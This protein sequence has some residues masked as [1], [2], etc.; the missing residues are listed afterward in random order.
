MLWP[1]LLETRLRIDHYSEKLSSIA[2]LSGEGWAELVAQVFQKLADWSFPWNQGHKCQKTC[3]YCSQWWSCLRLRMALL[4]SL[5][6]Y[7]FH[8][9]I[10]WTPKGSPWIMRQTCSGR[11]R[12]C[13]LD[14]LSNE[15]HLERLQLAYALSHVWY[16]RQLRSGGHHLHT[17]HSK[18]CS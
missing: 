8:L 7:S 14:S 5:H 2:I 16:G 10:T 12:G 3:Q 11:D 9:W 1:L 6:L 15:S 17:S 18:C 13:S 4:L